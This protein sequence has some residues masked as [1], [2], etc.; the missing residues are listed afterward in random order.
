MA[1][2]HRDKLLDKGFFPEVLPPCFD[3]EKLAVSFRGIKS[4]LSK[5]ALHRKRD[6]RYSRYSGTKHSGGR[7]AYAT[8]NPI[9]YF[10]VANFIGKHWEKIESKLA[11][12]EFSLDA[13]KF[14]DEDSD[15]AI[16]IASLNSLDEA[17]SSRMGYSPYML[18]SDISQFYPSIYTHSISWAFH[19]I[20]ESKSDLDVKSKKVFFNQLDYVVQKCQSQQTR[21]LLVGPDAF[22]LIAEIISTDMDSRISTLIDKKAVG[23]VRYV[24]DYYFGC[25]DELDAAVI[26]SALRETLAT[27]E[28]QVNDHKT[29]IV[30]TKL[31]TDDGW[32]DEIR[33][34]RLNA[35][36]PGMGFQQGPAKLL[37]DAVRYC[38]KFE[39][40]SPL[41][42][43]VRRLD[44]SRVVMH[45]DE[46]EKVEP[47]LQRYAYHYPHCLDYICLLVAKRVATGGD[48]DREG[49]SGVTNLVLRRGFQFG[50][51]HE[52]CWLLWLSFIAKFDID[53][54]LLGLALNSRNSHISSLTWAAFS[55]G[56][57]TLDRRPKHNASFNSTEAD[58]LLSLT[59]RS[60][61]VSSRAFSGQLRSEFEHLLDNK[62]KLINFEK[63]MKSASNISSRA[64]SRSKFG[65]DD[66][67][68]VDEDYGFVDSDDE[69][70]F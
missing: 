35:L 24:D 54:D 1:A 8:V 19:G 21:G 18:K 60:H 46:W 40:A 25:R 17:I 12:S 7:R 56:L 16:Q 65:Y 32:A 30:P 11:S 45:N 22:R 3:S 69:I 58:W 23:V 50:Y 53:K 49:W 26:L 48:V 38:E 41:K 47:R 43:A 57:F 27:F 9:P 68:N 42:L 39:S 55:E 33:E 6:C 63:Y 2:H 44:E 10:Q 13:P 51:H 31:P 66:D 61:G 4:E 34:R 37:D 70:P 14:T 59:L 29:R 28:L 15:R 62:I 20:Q 67:E 36:V 64:I 5:K 52:V